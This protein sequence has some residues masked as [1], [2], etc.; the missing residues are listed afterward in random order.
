MEAI[1]GFTQ[2]WNKNLPSASRFTVLT[3]FR[4]TAVRDNNT[5]LVSEQAPDDIHQSQLGFT[6]FGY[7]TLLVRG[8]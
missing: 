2:N 8:T 7:L 4:G 3:S 1:A 5:G 6:G